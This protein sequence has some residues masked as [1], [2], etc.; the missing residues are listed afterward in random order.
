MGFERDFTLL[1]GGGSNWS[2]MKYVNPAH[3]TLNFTL[4]GK[5]LDKLPDD[6]FSSKA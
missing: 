5:P 2:D 6:H 3:S 1:Q 4:N